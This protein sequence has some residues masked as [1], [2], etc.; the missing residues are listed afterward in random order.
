MFH[1]NMGRVNFLV[2]AGSKLGF[3]VFVFLCFPINLF[4]FEV[5]TTREQKNCHSCSLFFLNRYFRIYYLFLQFRFQILR[6][7]AD[8]IH[9]KSIITTRLWLINHHILNNFRKISY[10]IYTMTHSF[11]FRNV[12]TVDGRVKECFIIHLWCFFH[13]LYLTFNWRMANVSC[14]MA[15]VSCTMKLCDCFKDRKKHFIDEWE[16][17]HNLHFLHTLYIFNVDLI[18]SHV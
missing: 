5:K 16:F 14:T 12:F 8:E 10:Q 7:L 1:L 4:H 2:K 17:I 18:G 11:L 3:F 13:G 6:L 15:N 9:I